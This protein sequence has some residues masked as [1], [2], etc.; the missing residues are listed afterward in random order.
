MAAAGLFDR[1]GL[2]GT[3][4]AAVADAANVTRGAVYWHFQDKHALF[5]AVCAQAPLPLEMLPAAVAVEREDDPLGRFRAACIAALRQAE[6]D[7]DALRTFA[8]PVDRE[9]LLDPAG[10]L[11][12]RHRH[13]LVQSKTDIERVLRCAME[14]RQLPA[15]LD[16]ELASTAVHSAM[17][18]LLTEWLLAPGGVDLATRAARLLD[19]V[20]GSMLHAPSMR[21]AP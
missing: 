19:A 6:A 21:R 10:V 13:S 1:L 11:L 8:A 5:E 3:T 2:D 7:P 4:L 9:E 14:K 20:I 18:G 12:L 17:T 15:E 16:L